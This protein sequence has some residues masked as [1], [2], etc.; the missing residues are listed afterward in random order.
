MQIK[1]LEIRPH[2]NSAN[3]YTENTLKSKVSPVK[4]RILAVKLPKE[5]ELEMVTCPEISVLGKL[6]Q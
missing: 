4:E 3:F 2:L 6:R 1:E 5:L